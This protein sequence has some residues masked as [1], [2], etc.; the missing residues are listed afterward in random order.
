MYNIK[1]DKIIF[2]KNGG[3]VKKAGIV[4]EVFLPIQSCKLQSLHDHGHKTHVCLR[5]EMTN[6]YSRGL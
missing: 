4:R 5:C 2:G 6:K 1:R 3:G